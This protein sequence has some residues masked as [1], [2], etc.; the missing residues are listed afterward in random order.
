MTAINNIYQQKVS[1]EL[2]LFGHNLLDFII[3]VSG[4]E[5][6]YKIQWIQAGFKD[7]L[8][9]IP[10]GYQSNQFIASN[11]SVDQFNELNV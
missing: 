7:C 4:N 8:L 5:V 10:N 9:F 3:P 2:L 11:W 1:Q 6:S